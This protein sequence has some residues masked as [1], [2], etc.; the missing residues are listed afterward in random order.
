MGLM[1][2]LL[3]FFIS[4]SGLYEAFFMQQPSV[5]AGILFFALLFAP[6]DFFAGLV[7]KS[8]SRRNEFEA[9][10]FAVAAT[11]NPTAM[12][13]ALKKLASD[14][15]TNLT[16]HPLYVFLNYTHPPMLERIRAILNHT[17][18]GGVVGGL[19]KGSM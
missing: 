8:L 11:G 5:Y 2:F 9:D 18:E 14:N 16:P 4:Y 19:K 15:L 12:I 7:M 13:T 17:S 10:R 3:S 6:I 1:L